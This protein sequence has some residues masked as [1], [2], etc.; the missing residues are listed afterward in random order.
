MAT[1]SAFMPA[2]AEP[3]PTVE[4]S[5]QTAQPSKKLAK[6]LLLDGYSTR[7]LACV[8]SWGRKGVEFVVGGES[9]WD[10]SLFSRYAREKFVYTSPKRDLASFI[11]DVNDNSRRFSADCVFPTSEAAILACSKYRKELNCIPLVPRE[12]EIELTF[13]KTNT[14]RIAESLGIPVPQTVHVTVANVALV[15]SIALNFPVAIKSASSEVM[16]STNARTSAKTAYAFNRDE[17]RTECKARL[18]RGESVLVQEFIDGYGVGISGLFDSGRPVALIAHRR[19]RESNPLGGPSAVAE[20]ITPDAGLLRLTTALLERI[21]L[22]GPAMVEYKIER[23][24]G[25][26]F[27]MEINGRFWGSVLLAVAAGLDLPYLYWKMLNGVEILPHEINYRI[28]MR[29]RY[30]IGDTKCLLLSL[31]GKPKRWPGGFA[32]RRLALSSYLSS[33]FDKRTTELILSWDDPAP[34]VGRLLQPNS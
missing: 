12:R 32:G 10:M 30:L 8:R 26:P 23:R 1:D 15:E 22:T 6:V 28:G 33:F 2:A 19:I 20:T 34:F 17:L 7:T 25:R 13:S 11:R 4:S 14:L 18:S 27:L 16:H 21:G 9:R 5:P 31:K 3:A 29:G 24:S